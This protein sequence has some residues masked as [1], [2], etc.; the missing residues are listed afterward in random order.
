MFVQNIFRKIFIKL[1]AG[2]LLLSVLLSPL[3]MWAAD[4]AKILQAVPAPNPVKAGDTVN[5]QVVIKNVGNINWP[6]E[7]YSIKAEIYSKDKELILNSSAL[8]GPFDTAPGETA[9][10]YL[11]F[12]V[13]QDF[14]GEYYFKIDLD[15]NGNRVLTSD[16]YSFQTIAVNQ[17][18]EE[19]VPPSVHFSGNIL[20]SYKNSSLTNYLGN[21]TLNMMGQVFQKTV[22]FNGYVDYDKTGNYQLTR[23][24]LSY[25]DDWGDLQLGDVTPEL[26]SFTLSNLLIRGGMAEVHTNNNL[27]TW[28]AV[29]AR[30]KYP[31]E[32]TSLIAG[33]Y[34]RDL[35]GGRGAVDLPLFGFDT[36]SGVS[37]SHAYDEQNSISTPGPGVSPVVDDVYAVDTTWKLPNVIKITAEAAQS[38]YNPNALTTGAN[39]TDIAYRLNTT[40]LISSATVNVGY[41]KRGNEL[42]FAGKPG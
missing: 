33:I 26:S 19:A 32:G 1:F 42:L 22:S 38:Q 11:P 31:S 7:Q 30:V 10:L 4:F 18:E 28:T 9:L 37:Y 29:A 6:A 34:A 39:T 12:N 5:F 8:V 16:F 25:Y 15:H 41:R 27:F 2:A 17:A 20:A 23:G 3:E 36:I 14:K 13:P 24:L 21:I 40:T 35:W